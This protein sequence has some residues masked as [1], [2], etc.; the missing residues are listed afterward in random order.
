MVFWDGGEVVFG[1]KELYVEQN[2]EAGFLGLCQI[3]QP[4]KKRRLIEP[5]PSLPLY[6]QKEQHAIICITQ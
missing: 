6:K 1:S 2:R 5:D 4:A 3:N